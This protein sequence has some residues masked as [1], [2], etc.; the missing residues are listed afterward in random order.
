MTCNTSFVAIG[1]GNKTLF[2]N[3][4][5]IHTIS[6]DGSITTVFDRVHKDDSGQV[7]TSSSDMD[8]SVGAGV[9]TFT[10]V[11]EFLVRATTV[12]FFTEGGV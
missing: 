3:N 7:V 4:D 8:I 1:V 11:D 12:A 9:N 5:G 6:S 2:F 10:L